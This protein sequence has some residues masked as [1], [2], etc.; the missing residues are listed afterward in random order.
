MKLVTTVLPTDKGN[1]I[2]LVS[3]TCVQSFQVNSLND[4]DLLVDFVVQ[5]LHAAP[6]IGLCQQQGLLWNVLAVGTD[7]ST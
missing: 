1:A 4:T 2:V 3:V 6:C 7:S 5:D